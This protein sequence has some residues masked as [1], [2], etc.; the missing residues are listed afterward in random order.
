M[1]TNL[2]QNRKAEYLE[3]LMTLLAIPSV[4]TDPARKHEVTRCANEVALQMT[5]AGLQNIEILATPGHPVVYADYLVS[6][7]LP[8]ALIYGHYDVQP[9][10]PIELWT[11][12]P[13]EPTIRLSLIHI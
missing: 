7:E 11:S 6:S 9:E 12:P 8:T 10:D 13:F 2:T 5:K 3:D 1:S 4:S